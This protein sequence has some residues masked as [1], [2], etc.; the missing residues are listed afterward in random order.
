[1][2][3]TKKQLTNL[4]NESIRRILTEDD[5]WCALYDYFD[6]YGLNYV[7][8]E[9]QRDPQHNT[10]WLPLINPSEYQKALNEFTK[11]GQLSPYFQKRVY[12]WMGIILKNAVLLYD[13]T[14]IYGHTSS[15][16]MYAFADSFFEDYEAWQMY[17]QEHGLDDDWGGAY[18]YLES[19]G[20]IDWSDSGTDTPPYSDYGLEPIMDA[21]A[22]YNSD[23][24]PE[25]VLVLINKIIDINH[26]RGDLSALFIKGGAD[27]CDRISNGVYYGTA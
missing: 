8:S 17:A 21:A 27:A 22:T 16:D 18:E 15:F 2:D 12:Q 13:T 9:F 23:M 5:D 25:Q 24:T 20:F 6:D 1:M 11:T 7:F 19:I 26:C 4:I 3:I 14:E 10:M